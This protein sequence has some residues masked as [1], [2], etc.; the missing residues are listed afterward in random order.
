[1]AGVEYICDLTMM[2]SEII[3]LLY[4]IHAL[5]LHPIPSVHG[6]NQAEY[7]ADEGGLLSIVFKVNVKGTS[8][9]VL[10]LPGV[11]TAMPLTARELCTCICKYV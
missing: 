4:W 5:N 6:F 9:S 11:V 2:S 8:Q 1:M 3:I 7:M 10:F